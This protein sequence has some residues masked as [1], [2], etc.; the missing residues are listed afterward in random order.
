MMWNLF[1][2][3]VGLA[4]VVSVVLG[5]AGRAAAVGLIQVEVEPDDY[6]DGTILDNVSPWVTLS[7]GAFSDNRPTFSVQAKIDASAASTGTKVFAHSGIA[8]WNTSRTF[9]MD[10][11]AP[12]TSVSVDYIASG[13][14]SRVHTG[15][16]EAYSSS[17]S[18]LGFY[19][20]APLAG[21]QH[22]TMTVSVPGIAY[23][24]AYPPVD[25]FGD[26]D[27]LRF[28]VVPEPNSAGMMVAAGG[29]CAGLATVVARRRRHASVRM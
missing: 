4:V 1:G 9:R 2:R 22:E 27:H 7:T 14:F 16:L 29:G 3:A 26:M 5:L 23:A 28:T 17:G 18:L 19:E 12:A 8:F 24:L 6:T 10:F 15:R 21:A 20:T 11:H 13:F 25:P